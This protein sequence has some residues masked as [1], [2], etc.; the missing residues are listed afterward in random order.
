MLVLQDRAPGPDGK[1]GAA[2][3]YEK[4]VFGMTDEDC[5]DEFAGFQ[6]DFCFTCRVSQGNNLEV[7]MQDIEAKMGNLTVLEHECGE[8]LAS[9]EGANWVEDWILVDSGSA[10]HACPKD[11]ALENPTDEKA[12]L[13]P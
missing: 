10:T 13:G 2:L 4:M 1:T 6:E 12:S 8:L 9:L 5:E 7:V 11:Y 3:T